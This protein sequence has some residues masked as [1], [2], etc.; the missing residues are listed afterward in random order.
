MRTRP[1]SSAVTSVIIV[2]NLTR[3]P[4][5]CKPF[6][7]DMIEVERRE[8]Q[9]PFVNTAVFATEARLSSNLLA[10]RLVHQAEGDRVRRRRALAWRM[11]TKLPKRM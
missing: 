3:S 4:L 1:F 11:A 9:I 10:G 6:W 8:R 2:G 7:V 5:G